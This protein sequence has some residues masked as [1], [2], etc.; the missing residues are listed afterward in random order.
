M[1]RRTMNASAVKKQLT[2]F[3]IKSRRLAGVTLYL[4]HV[5]PPVYG[6]TAW[7][8]KFYFKVLRG[9]SRQDQW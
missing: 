1:G 7:L 5:D 4:I 2:V 8:S 6:A 3:Y 9:R